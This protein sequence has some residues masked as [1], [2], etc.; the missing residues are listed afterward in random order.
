MLARR[1][2]CI[3]RVRMD[4]RVVRDSKV[5]DVAGGRFAGAAGWC[6]RCAR[7]LGLLDLRGASWW[8]SGRM[9]F[10]L[11]SSVLSETSDPMKSRYE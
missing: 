5:G 11:D 2:L 8:M 4:D 9:Q 3:K 1:F 7:M 6:T 10:R